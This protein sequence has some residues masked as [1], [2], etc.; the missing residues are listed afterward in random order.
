MT[1]N[2]APQIRPAQAGLSNAQDI[3]DHAP[4]GIFKTTP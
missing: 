1:L 2:Q 3:L 4:I